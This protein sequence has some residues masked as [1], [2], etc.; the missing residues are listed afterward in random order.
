MCSLAVCKTY[1]NVTTF[2]G[3]ILPVEKEG[4]WVDL[5]AMI[6]PK[7]WAMVW[8]RANTLSSKFTITGTS[9]PVSSAVAHDL[10]C[11]VVRRGLFV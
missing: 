7:M 8:C 9:G 11:G 10:C 4:D 1:V 3:N 2:D 5:K 6:Q